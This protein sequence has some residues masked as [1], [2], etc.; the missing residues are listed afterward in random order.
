[1][2]RNENKRDAK[3]ASVQF[4]VNASDGEL[5]KIETMLTEL[6][7]QYSGVLAV[8]TRTASSGFIPVYVGTPDTYQEGKRN[9]SLEANPNGFYSPGIGRFARL[10]GQLKKNVT[11]S[12]DSLVVRAFETLS[13][14]KADP[15]QLGSF[16]T[17][18]E[19]TIASYSRSDL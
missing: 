12:S 15:A 14:Q 17:G 7:K 18:S 19:K 3:D 9:I 16:L 2:V 6:N 5:D 13:G 4:T 1:M 11:L 10:V 8:F